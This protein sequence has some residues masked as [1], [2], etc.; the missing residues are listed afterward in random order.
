[1]YK[2]V[3]TALLKAAR[4]LAAD[5]G[6]PG[7]PRPNQGT[8]RGERDGCDRTV[9]VALYH[10][11]TPNHPSRLQQRA[12]I[13]QGLERAWAGQDPGT[14]ASHEVLRWHFKTVM[15]PLAEWLNACLIDGTSVSAG[16]CT[17]TPF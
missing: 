2:A 6:C 12:E 16:S 4:W 1:M 15:R 13:G 10:T 5:S 8:A 17:N 14:V 9:W 11:P 3:L 7:T